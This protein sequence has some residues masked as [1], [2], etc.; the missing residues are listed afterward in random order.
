MGTVV[1]LVFRPLGIDRPW[2]G[3]ADHDA[4]RWLVPAALFGDRHVFLLGSARRT[5]TNEQK[6]Y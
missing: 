2:F 3:A 5:R 6:L 1:P 4:Q